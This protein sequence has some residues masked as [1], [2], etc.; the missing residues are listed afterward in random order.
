VSAIEH[1]HVFEFEIYPFSLDGLCEGRSPSAIRGK[2]DLLFQ[3]DN[4]LRTRCVRKVGSSS[5]GGLPTFHQTSTCLHEIDFEVC[6]LVNLVTLLADFRGNV[7]VYSTE[8]DESLTNGGSSEF[9]PA[10]ALPRLVTVRVASLSAFAHGPG[11][12]LNVES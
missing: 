1:H 12:L 3:V 2:G 5:H 4:Y 6:S 7:L 10:D 11:A 9:S 8:W